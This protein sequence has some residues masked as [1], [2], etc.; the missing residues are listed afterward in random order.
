MSFLDLMLQQD[1]ESAGLVDL[2]RPATSV[3]EQETIDTVEARESN[4][5]TS[6]PIESAG[7]T[8]LYVAT[9]LSCWETNEHRGIWREVVYG[10]V[11]YRR[12]D[13]EY[14]AWLRYKMVLAEKAQESGG[15]D[16]TAFNGLRTRF[17]LIHAWA[18]DRFGEDALL[19]AVSKFDPKTYS[20]PM[21]DIVSRSD[22]RT[23]PNDDHDSDSSTPSIDSYLFPKDGDWCFAKK[24]KPSA[25]TKVDAIRDQA[26]SLGWNE[27]RLYQN[28]GLFRFPCGED[29]GL[30]CFINDNDRIGEMTRH[31][32][33]IIGPPPRENRLR[34]YNPDVDQPWVKKTEN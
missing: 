16:P 10:R 24:V 22:S 19:S 5:I 18:I 27:Q 11:C 20:P 7:K 8:V 13:P 1:A 21:V 15:L 2:N 12:L 3:S 4:Q 32:I 33:E 17:N 23:Y 30:I 25:I 28:R 26:I 31:Y 14:Y 29:Y 6:P 9:N 34:F